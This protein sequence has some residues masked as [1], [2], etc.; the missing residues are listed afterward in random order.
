MMKPVTVAVLDDVA[1]YKFTQYFW[2]SML[3]IGWLGSVVVGCWTCDL[4]SRG[5]RFDSRLVHCWVAT[6]GK[7]FTPMWLCHQAASDESICEMK[8]TK[9]YNFFGTGQGAVMFCGW[10]G[11]LPVWHRTGHASQTQWSIHLRAQRP[12]CGRWASHLSSTGVCFP[13]C[14]MKRT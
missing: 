8:W 7:L 3:H 14:Y 11:N 6:P 9:Q 12:M 4:D 13:W 2:S 1:L 5:R 10:E